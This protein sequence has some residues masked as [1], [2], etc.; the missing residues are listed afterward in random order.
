MLENVK[1]YNII[2]AGDLNSRGGMRVYIEDMNGK[3]IAPRPPIWMPMEPKF[4][5]PHRA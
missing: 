4:E 3:T 2:T 1:D 5:K